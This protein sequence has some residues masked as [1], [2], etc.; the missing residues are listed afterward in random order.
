MVKSL[1]IALVGS[2]ALLVAAACSTKSQRAAPS[3]SKVISSQDIDGKPVGAATDKD[4]TIVVFF[5]TWCH[6]C[7]EELKMLTALRAD[8]PRVRIIGVN[9]YEE[10]SN[11]SNNE[12]LRSFLKAN[13]DWLQVVRANKD[14][15]DAFGGVP[16]IPSMFVFDSKGRMVKE[17]RRA[18][19]PPPSRHEVDQVL[20]GIKPA[21]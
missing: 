8:Q 6:P 18:K 16:K 12:K 15:F 7:R 9:A 2:V 11:Q 17:F 10:W 3:Y 1:R 20:A 4:A 5:A 21:A 13:A 14:L 19:R